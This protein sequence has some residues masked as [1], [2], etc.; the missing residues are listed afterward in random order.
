MAS[1]RCA[2]S[3]LVVSL[4]VSAFAQSSAPVSSPYDSVDPLIGTTATGNVFPGATLPFGMIQWSPDTGTEGWYDYAKSRIYGFS[5]THI[6]GAGCPLYGD[7]PV[8]PWAGDVTVSPHENR[9]LYT[10]AFSHANESAHPGFYAVTLDNGTKVEL[11]VT[12]RA[13]IAHFR[14]PKGVPAR[15]LLNAGGSANSGIIDKKPDDPAR[16]SDGFT[17]R[18]SGS[19]GVEGEARSGAFCNSPTRYT[20]YMAAQFQQPFERTVMWHDDTLDASA[21]EEDAHHAGAWLDFGDRR[22]V[23]MKVGLSF[24]SIANARK[25]LTAEIPAWDFNAVHAA[26]RRTWTEVLDR[27]GIEGG[28][29]A[30]RTIFYT[31]LYHMLLSPNLFS[32]RNGD[33]TG[34][35][36]KVHYLVMGRP[37][38]T[39]AA[40][41][42]QLAQY[43]NFSD[44]DIYRDVI[45]FQSLFDPARTA[46]MAHSLVNDAA[47]SGWLPRWPAANDVTYVMGGDSPTILLADA[48]AFGARNFDTSTALHYMLKAANEPGIGPHR[49]SERPFLAEE[50]KLGYIPVD[51]DSIDGSRT[52]EYASDNFAI[53]QFARSMGDASS[54]DALMK[55]AGNWQNL[56]DPETKWIRPRN[57]DGSWLKGFDP[58]H[59]LPKRDNAP[60]S[61]DQLGFEEGNTWQYSFMIPFDYPRLIAVM[62]GSAAVVP[63]LNKFFSKLICWGEPCFNMANEPDFVTPYVYEYTDAPWKTDDV[64]TRI[65]QQTFST[66]PD[67]IPG[68]DDLGA[69]SGV[70]VWNALG[71]YPGVPGVGGF[72]IG[73]PMFPSATVHF[74]E[75]RTLVVT[76][77]GTGPYVR[78]I[79]LNGQPWKQ[80]WLPL[81]QVPAHAT[82][83]LHF[84]LQPGE[85]T[86]TT[87]EAPPTFRP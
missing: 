68:N 49:E 62:G 45:Q 20:V 46:D 86:S 57:A 56:F 82:T 27:I 11:T 25:N 8:L 67:G 58:E 19:D 76:S 9:D 77:E 80:L 7:F 32:D 34:F 69:T 48:Y 1:L 10:V 15:L 17:I 65:E 12:E 61:T 63:R 47:E 35:D 2:V 50:L 64:V 14:F 74:G 43:A 23:T 31:G 42:C 29:P 54:A 78:A 36:S 44:W 37:H 70:Y 53:A 73:T 71:L 75:G 84:V 39:C 79:T 87:L 33:Y 26:A 51:Q 85:P 6:S 5:L 18:L 83:T 81:D 59:S 24:V 16:A 41:A 21:H 66:K 3:L 22:E 72:F 60:V 4:A 13:G 55:R 38:R 52:L 30:Q 40:D 28:T